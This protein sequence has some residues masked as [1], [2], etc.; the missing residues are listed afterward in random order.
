MRFMQIHADILGPRKSCGRPGQLSPRVN[1][2]IIGSVHEYAATKT[3]GRV[4]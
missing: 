1:I 2:N 3:R 4:G